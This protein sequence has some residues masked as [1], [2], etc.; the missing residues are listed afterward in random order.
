MAGNKYLEK[1]AQVLGTEKQA[2]L[3][4]SAVSLGK[5]AVGAVK[6]EG[7]RLG[8]DVKDLLRK[9]PA[10]NGMPNGAKSKAFIAK[11]IAKNRIAQAGAAGAVG[12]AAGSLMSSKKQ[13]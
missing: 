10:A 12:A 6:T 13:D 7:A 3:M 1:I 9:T 11:N 5:R 4:S 8:A 2:G